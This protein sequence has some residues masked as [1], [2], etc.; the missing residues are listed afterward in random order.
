MPL[1][2]NIIGDDDLPNLEPANSGESNEIDIEVAGNR[3]VTVDLK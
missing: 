3:S 2:G 1:A